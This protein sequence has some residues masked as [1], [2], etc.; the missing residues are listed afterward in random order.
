MLDIAEIPLHDLLDEV[1]SRGEAVMGDW[2][3]RQM[4][5]VRSLMKEKAEEIIDKATDGN[6]DPAA[7]PI[8]IV[9]LA[10]HKYPADALQIGHEYL[11]RAAGDLL[12]KT[13]FA[14]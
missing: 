13:K 2:F 14:A 11:L 10:F 9:D 5:P 6:V 1:A 3:Y 7:D 4:I 12:A 8:G